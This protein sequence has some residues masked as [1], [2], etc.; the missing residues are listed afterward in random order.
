MPNL[1]PT[2]RRG[3]ESVPANQEIVQTQPRKITESS[4]ST[5]NPA[6]VIK[7][8]YYST[9]DA[10]ILQSRAM[11]PR[12][13]IDSYDRDYSNPY[14]SDKELDLN[15]CSSMVHQQGERFWGSKEEEER[16]AF[17]DYLSLS[18]SPPLRKKDVI[19]SHK[20]H[21]PFM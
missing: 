2:T 10:E 13:Q 9:N 5:E 11:L 8:V 21:S 4:N 16:T 17:R 1:Q 15:F 6:P 14:K 19:C 20:D 3:L 12:Y 18:L 7:D